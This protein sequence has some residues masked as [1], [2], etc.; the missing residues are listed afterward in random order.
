[1]T[2]KILKELKKVLYDW[3][4]KRIKNFSVVVGQLKEEALQLLEHDHGLTFSKIHISVFKKLL[5]IKE[6]DD[7]SPLS[8]A[9][10]LVINENKYYA[11][12]LF[13][14]IE[15]EI[16]ILNSNDII[17][18]ESYKKI[19]TL[20]GFLASELL[21]IGYAKPYIFKVLLNLYSEGS[22]YDFNG[23]FQWLKKLS[24]R[25]HEDYKVV[26]K[27]TI[28]Y[29]DGI[30]LSNFLLKESDI[31]FLQKINDDCDTFFSRK[32]RLAV[33]YFAIEEKGLDYFS[34][35]NKA[36]RTVSRILDS[37][38]LGFQESNI[39]LYPSALVV[40]SLRPEYSK[41]GVLIL[42]LMVILKV[43][44]NSMNNFMKKSLMCYYQLLLHKRQKINYFHQFT[45]CV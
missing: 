15:E 20:L 42:I 33:H 21:D 28:K 9:I 36:Y 12:E 37:L 31:Q 39:F 4:G 13:G 23:A 2:N 18:I 30:P 16:N 38:H 43:I 26:F 22:S 41:L 35:L 10:Q 17:D 25:P 34:V 1:M 44:K 32:E 27:M 45:T 40:G 11:L 6:G 24:N 3:K 7:V 14:R 8:Y 5:D 19:N 29:K